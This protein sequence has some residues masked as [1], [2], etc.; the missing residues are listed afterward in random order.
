MWQIHYGRASLT[1]LSRTPAFFVFPR[2][3]MDVARVTH[4]IK[5]SQL[6]S[7]VRDGSETVLSII[8]QAHIHQQAALHEA[9]ERAEPDS[10]RGSK[11]WIWATIPSPRL[12]PVASG[13]GAMKG[14][15]S[16]SQETASCCKQ[17]DD[18]SERAAGYTWNSDASTTAMLWIGTPDTSTLEHLQLTYNTKSWWVLDTARDPPSLEEGLPLAVRRLLRRRYALV[19]RARH[20]NIV[21]M[22]LHLRI[23]VV[24]EHAL[25]FDGGIKSVLRLRV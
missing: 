17:Q 23:A 8:D 14:D 15:C 11:N 22:S 1:P 4:L 16:H 20:A 13:T 10:M 24:D 6:W 18:G 21:G 3:D 12:D 25:L 7:R 9:L 5:S 19:E 2:Q